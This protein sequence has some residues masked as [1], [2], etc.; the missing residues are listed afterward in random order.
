MT[1]D[2]IVAL[3]RV[4]LHR[5]IPVIQQELGITQRD[6]SERLGRLVEETLSS[7]LG[8]LLLAGVPMT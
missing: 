5:Q 1:G 6:H 3:A 2:P 7:Q 4:M 8:A